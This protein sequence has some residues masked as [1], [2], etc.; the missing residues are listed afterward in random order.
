MSVTNSSANSVF[1]SVSLSVDASFHAGRNEHIDFA[2]LRS[3]C[4]CVCCSW[5]GVSETC[6]LLSEPEGKVCSLQKDAHARGFQAQDGCPRRV[7]GWRRARTPKPRTAATWGETIG[8]F[9]A[10]L[11]VFSPADCWSC[12]SAGEGPDLHSFWTCGGLGRGDLGG[13]R[14]ET[15]Q[16]FQVQHRR[17]VF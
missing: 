15:W 11:P 1:V 12:S 16:L 6:A 4:V 9:S 7:T 17:L 8:L 13:G 2:L 10:S 14:S 3:Q 5:M